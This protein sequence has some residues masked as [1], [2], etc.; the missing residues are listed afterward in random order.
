MVKIVFVRITLI[1][2]VCLGAS[3]LLAQGS[4]KVL[5]LNQVDV[6]QVDDNWEN[7]ST[8]PKLNPDSGLKVNEIIEPTSEYTYASFGKPDPFSIPSSLFASK[9][10]DASISEAGTGSVDLGPSS[11]EITV[12]SPLQAYPISVL[13]VKGVWQTA[14]GEFRAVVLTPKKEG[15]VVKVGDPISSGKIIGIQR[16]SLQVR[17]YK[18]RK[19]GVRE[20]DDTQIHF[21]SGKSVAKSTIKLEPGKEAKFPGM[22]DPA[23]PTVKPTPNAESP[24]GPR[25]SPPPGFI[26]PDLKNQ[27]AKAGEAPAAAIPA[28]NG[29]APVATD[30]V[31]AQ[32][33][34]Q[35]DKKELGWPY[36]NGNQNKPAEAGSIRP[37]ATRN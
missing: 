21:G 29:A 19:D 9:D 27:A 11:K 30:A 14:E 28:G 33:Q 6:E 7:T 8:V 16:D 24:T 26:N 34:P 32:A 4:P 37:G 36:N 17:L 23:S 5:D 22:E 12:T 3:R 35:G 20:Y 1:L 15:I 25:A 13:E 31:K 2:L 18:L 10:T